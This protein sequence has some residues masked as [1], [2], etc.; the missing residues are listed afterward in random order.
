[1]LAIVF[2]CE[3]FHDYLYAH[4][5]VVV[6]TDHKPLETILNKTMHQAPLRLQKMIL[7]TK[8]Y[9]LNVKYIPGSH[10]ALAK[11]NCLPMHMEAAD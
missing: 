1:M 5:E 9:A 3:R 11:A 2:G 6:E 7:R 8:P 10:L 4:W